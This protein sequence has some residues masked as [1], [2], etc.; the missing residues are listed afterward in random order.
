MT[1]ALEQGAAF[2]NNVNLTPIYQPYSI[3]F[4]VDNK[5][6]VYFTNYREWVDYL[7]EAWPC[8]SYACFVTEEK[9]SLNIHL[10]ALKFMRLVH[11]CNEIL[12]YNLDWHE[13]NGVTTA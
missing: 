13:H 12:E 7:C 5:C 4:M 8:S 9:E 6:P 1:T 2:W 11:K 10:A 3:M